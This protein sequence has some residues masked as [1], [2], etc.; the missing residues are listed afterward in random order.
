MSVEDVSKLQLI[1]KGRWCLSV[2]LCVSLLAQ[3]VGVFISARL[4]GWVQTSY[5][6]CSEAFCALSIVLSVQALP[7]EI[8][9][10]DGNKEKRGCQIR[11]SMTFFW[12]TV[13]QKMRSTMPQTA[14]HSH[15]LATH[16]HTSSYSVFR[17]F[18]DN[19]PL[20][21]VMLLCESWIHPHSGIRTRLIMLAMRNFQIRHLS[22][23]MFPLMS[24]LCHSSCIS[25]TTFHS[26]WPQTLAATPRDKPGVHLLSWRNVP[27][28]INY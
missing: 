24:P 26:D 10:K 12:L 19:S 20:C 7:H 21:G 16:A 4:W 2:L 23:K 3:K 27:W 5:I 11:P 9:K 17:I 28:V 1:H 15:S 18:S 22:H 14:T 25:C 6:S 13:L 8:C